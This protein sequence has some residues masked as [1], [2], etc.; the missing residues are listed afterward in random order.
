MPAKATPA[1]EDFTNVD[2]TARRLG[3]GPRRLR[4]GVNHHGWPGF[5]MGRR[6]MFSAE[7]RAQIAE[8]HRIP[9]RGG[10]RRMRAA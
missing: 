9:A 7:D 10:A 6:L 3:I 8:M 2:E 4:D 1:I 5:R